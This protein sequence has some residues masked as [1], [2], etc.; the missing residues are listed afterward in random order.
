[1]DKQTKQG[2]I[3][4]QYQLRTG[5]PGRKCALSHFPTR[6]PRT[7]GPTD[8]RTDT[9]S[10]TDANTHWKKKKQKEKKKKTK[11]KE[12]V[13]EK[14]S[15]P[16]KSCKTKSPYF[17]SVFFHFC[18]ITKW[19]KDE[20]ER[21]ER[22]QSHKRALWTITAKNT[23]ISTGPLDRPFARSLAPDCSLCSRP[24]L[25]SIVRSLTSLTP[26][27]VG[28]LIIGWLFIL[29]FSVLAQRARVM[30]AAGCLSEIC[31]ISVGNPPDTNAVMR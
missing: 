18:L 22:R 2:R 25:R 6:S 21:R 5:G 27:L 11:K 7:N 9:L 24:P 17:Q 13:R 14:F 23:D 28:Q 10:Y 1:M 19:V 15:K 3:H 20:R 26:S 4:G 16:R 8:R 29:F 12:R 30:R 31:R